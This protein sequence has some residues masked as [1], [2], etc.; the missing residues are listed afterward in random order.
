V[1]D[2]ACP[3]S[4]RGGEGG[5]ALVQ[6][7]QDHG[8]V[9]GQQRCIVLRAAR[10][11]RGRRAPGSLASCRL[12]RQRAC[13]TRRG[14]SVP[15]PP[16][17]ST[18]RHPLPPPSRTKWTRLVHPSVLSGHVSSLSHSHR[19][20]AQPPRFHHAQLWPF[21]GRVRRHPRQGELAGLRRSSVKGRTNLPATGREEKCSVDFLPARV[22]SASA[23][24]A[25]GSTC[26]T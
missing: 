21:R 18:K 7:A 23:D 14:R 11:R 9:L 6:L 20:E 15:L 16:G 10:R 1:R 3:L 22:V 19:R 24:V 8:L 26:G 13:L 12:L 5:H 17:T 4:T 2:A 25:A